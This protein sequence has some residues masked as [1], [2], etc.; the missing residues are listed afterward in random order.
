MLPFAFEEC[1]NGDEEELDAINNELI[2]LTK[3]IGK[4]LK[5][6]DLTF[7]GVYTTTIEKICQNCPNLETVTQNFDFS[8]LFQY[9]Q[10]KNFI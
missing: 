10:D 3:K 9:L 7:T 1:G 8:V 5:K 4:T 6:I 2:T